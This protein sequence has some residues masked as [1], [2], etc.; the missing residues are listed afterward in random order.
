MTLFAVEAADGFRERSFYVYPTGGVELLWA[1]T[2]EEEGDE[3]FLNATEM[4]IV[5]AQLADAVGRRP[6][7]DLSRA[8]RGRRRFARVDWNFNLATG[9]CFGDRAIVSV[10]F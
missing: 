3:I 7:A 2:P 9:E 10:W 4:T 8:G 6:W 5:I 1:L